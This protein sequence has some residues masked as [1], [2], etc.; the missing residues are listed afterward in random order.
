M[1]IWNLQLRQSI[2]DLRVDDEK[3]DSQ[4]YL[5]HWMRGK[6]GAK[7]KILLQQPQ[8]KRLTLVQFLG[9]FMDVKKAE[10]AIREVNCGQLEIGPLEGR[11]CWTF[12]F[13][14]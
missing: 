9:N 8:L 14:F 4:L 12:D 7:N 1:E 6:D 2:K 3:F 5:Y 13:C 10:K 11:L